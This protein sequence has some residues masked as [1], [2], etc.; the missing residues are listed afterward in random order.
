MS[1]WEVIA[2]WK[3]LAFSPLPSWINCWNAAWVEQRRWDQSE[4][5]WAR[6]RHTKTNQTHPAEFH[7]Y[8]HTAH[9]VSPSAFCQTKLK[10]PWSWLL[11]R[12]LN[13]KKDCKRVIT[14]TSWGLRNWMR[15]GTFNHNWWITQSD[16]WRA[17]RFSRACLIPM[18][19]E[20]VDLLPSKLM[21][22]V[23]YAIKA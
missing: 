6:S 12:S 14:A 16:C 1:W 4:D 10:G 5:E 23:W 21:G 15:G 17:E 9:L 19:M 11:L 8:W 13:T 2:V 22:T 3:R 18:Q 20:C 7:F